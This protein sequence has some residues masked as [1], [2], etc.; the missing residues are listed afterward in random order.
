MTYRYFDFGAHTDGSVALAAFVGLALTAERDA[1]APAA[2]AVGLDGV[3]KLEAPVMAALIAALRRVRE[4]G[5]TLALVTRRDDIRASL[6][7][8]G[9]DRVFNVVATAPELEVR[10]RDDA[11]AGSASHA[12][13]RRVGGFVAALALL[14]VPMG[15]FAQDSTELLPSAPA[16][17]DKLIERNPA[18]SSFQA[19]VDV[20]MRMTSFPW[21]APSLVGTTYFKRPNSYE[22]VFRS[23]PFWAKGFDKIYT[24]AGDPS[25]WNARFVVEVRGE[26][27]IEGRRDIE[28]RMVQRV[29][30]Q[31]DHETIF[32]DPARWVVDRVEYAYYNGGSIV[33]DQRFREQD[34]FSLIAEQSVR[35]KLPAVHAIG[36]AQ[37]TDYH[38]NV[39]VDDTVFTKK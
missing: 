5:G 10:E 8:T 23:V 35:I 2:I 12:K 3:T 20:H 30:G 33:L 4:T 16:I 1:S 39:A 26:R 19:H 28:L 25:S 34:G 7:A 31:I 14:F 6:R 13:V 24:D 9:L 21:Y 17:V 36:T 27:T 11:H 18:L 22:V 29:R 38:T 32:V 37:Y 15:A